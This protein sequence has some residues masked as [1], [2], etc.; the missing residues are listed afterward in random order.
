MR[1]RYKIALAALGLTAV[2]LLAACGSGG[3]VEETAV[4]SSETLA[5][6]ET[7]YAAECA[8]CHGANLE[9]QPNWQTPNEDGSFRAPPHDETGHTWHHGDGYILER[10][11]S[12]TQQLDPQ[13]QSKS[14]MPAYDDKLTEDE[15]IAVLR[16]IQSRW[17]EEVRDRQAQ[18]TEAE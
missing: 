1:K 12:G 13:M 11:R 5:L 10:M 6:G 7:V 15:M 8:A 14:N 3:A 9:G 18:A 16:Y 2:V 4:V 17:P